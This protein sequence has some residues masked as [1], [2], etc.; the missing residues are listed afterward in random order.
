[1]K[2]NTRL[3]CLLTIIIFYVSCEK[4]NASSSNSKSLENLFDNR[5]ISV[6]QGIKMYKEHDLKRTK[7]L[8]P[9]LQEMYND[10]TFVDTKFV[11]FSLKDMKD[12]ISFLEHV[13]EQNPDQEVSGVRVYFGTYPESSQ[14]F[15]N[16]IKNPNQQTV[17]MVPTKNIG[18]VDPDYNN[19]NNIPFYIEGSRDNPYKGKFVI[20]DELM[21]DY[22][23][24]ERL[25]IASANSQ[26]QKASLLNLQTTEDKVVTSTLFNEGEMSPPP[27]KNKK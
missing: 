21:L 27:I 9:I 15:E 13:Q 4:P 5:I 7:L 10:S 26:V 8:S 23:K 22:N 17:F 18:Q 2:T 20:I 19:M 24:Q 16:N 12:Y 14:N 3:L 6:E 25:D 11:Y 1:M